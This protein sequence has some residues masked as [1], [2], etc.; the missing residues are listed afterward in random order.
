MP[1]RHAVLLTLLESALPGSL[2]SC[3]QNAVVSYFFSIP[4]SPTQI[5]ENKVTLNPVE[6][7][8]ARLLGSADSKALIAANILPQLL[9]FLHFRDPLGSAHSKELINPVESALAEN[10]PATPVE[11]ALTKIRGV[12]A[13][14]FKELTSALPGSF[15]RLFSHPASLHPCFLAGLHYNR[16]AFVRGRNEPEP[17]F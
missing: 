7:A 16:C 13:P 17:A 15:S 3:K 5:I 12:G 1:A 10:L 11:S 4:C 6:S 2:L 14:V 8:L 9:Y